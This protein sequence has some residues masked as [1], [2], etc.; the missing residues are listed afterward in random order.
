VKE[1]KQQSAEIPIPAASY[2]VLRNF[3]SG[4]RHALCCEA[5]KSGFIPAAS[6]GEFKFKSMN[7]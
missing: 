1:I 6:N 2:R 4:L 5:A 3:G 7:Q